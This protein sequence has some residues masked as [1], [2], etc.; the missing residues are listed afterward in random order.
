LAATLCPE[1]P[2]CE[3]FARL[4]AEKASVTTANNANCKPT[5]LTIRRPRASS[6]NV[7]PVRRRPKF[8]MICTKE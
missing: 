3:T 2:M 7:V 5:R 8:I 4:V 1:A 6:R